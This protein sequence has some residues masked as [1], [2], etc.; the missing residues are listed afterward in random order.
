MQAILRGKFMEQTQ[1]VNTK[2]GETTPV[3]NIYSGSEVVK[4]IGCQCDAAFG[5]DVA[6]PVMISQGNYG[7]Y[8]RV[9]TDEKEV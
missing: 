1:R 7:L 8:V 2:T 9:Q 5:D 6:I 4:V 3:A